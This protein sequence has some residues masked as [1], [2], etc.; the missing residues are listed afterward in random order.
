METVTLIVSLLTL[1]VASAAFW[2]ALR[3]RAQDMEPLRRAMAELLEAQR[4]DLAER[5]G[6]V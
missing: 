5:I 6:R 1:V 4:R 3:P 2:A